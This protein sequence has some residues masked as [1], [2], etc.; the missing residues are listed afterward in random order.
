MTRL[1]ERI[2]E[3]IS[4]NSLLKHPFYQMWSNGELNKEHLAGYS[5]E[6]FQ[7]VSAVPGLVGNALSATNAPYSRKMISENLEEETLHIELWKRFCSSLG[8]STEELASQVCPEKTRLSVKELNE[9]TGTSFE[10]AVAAMYAYESEIPKISAAKIEG[11]KRFYGL[12]SQDA[13]TYFRT[14]E[15]ADVR[16]AAVWREILG[17]IE[18]ER[19]Q[20]LAFQAAARSLKAQ[21]SLLDSVMEKYV[22]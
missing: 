6:Y 21:N 3:E 10:E 1:I 8:V 17:R 7:L 18:D 13:L 12:D 15:E 14:H 11:L 16:H 19:K 9:I 22:S 5:K 2:D 20:E 4:R